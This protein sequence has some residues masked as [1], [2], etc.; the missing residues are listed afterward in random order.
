MSEETSVVANKTVGAPGAGTDAC[1]TLAEAF[2]SLGLHRPMRLNRYQAG[3]ELTYDVTGVS[4]AVRATVRLKIEK[5]VGGGFAGQ[6]YRATVLAVEGQPIAGLDVGGTYALK[7]L[8]PPSPGN[9]RFRDT[10]YAVGFQGPFSLQVNPAAMRAGAIWQK[11][12]RRASAIRFSD[13]GAVKDILCTFVDGRLGSCGELSEW[14]EGRQWRFE[15]DDHIDLRGKYLRGKPVEVAQLGSPEYLAKRR[16]MAEFVA[17]LHEMG[18]PEL[19][20]QYEWGT[21]KSQ[22]NV[23]KRDGMDD[24][25]AAGLTALD[26]RA[27]LALLPFLPM[28]PGDFRLIAKGIARGSLVQFDRGD[29]VRLE[30]FMN[31]H[32]DRF[33]DLWP[34]LGELQQVEKAY[35]DS[36]PD[37]THHHVRL[38]C[39]GQLWGSILDG[40]V[41]SWR[42]RNVTDDATT[43]ALRRSRALT[44][45]F[46]LLGLVGMVC[47]L[48]AACVL[49]L[50]ILHRHTQP[51]TLRVVL[52]ALVFAVVGPLAGKLFRRVAGREDYR[53]HYGAV[54]SSPG[55]FC[56]ALRGRSIEKVMA[57]YCAGRMSADRAVRTAGSPGR[58]LLHL[59]LSFLPA[60]LHRFLTDRA[61][62]GQVMRNVALRPVHLYFNAQARESWLRDM[63][64][65]GRRRGML[66]AE[67]AAEI[68][69]RLHE[70]FIQKYLKSLAV[71]V[72]LMPAGHVI[73]AIIGLCVALKYGKSLGE[74]LVIAG[75]IVAFFQVTPISPGSCLRGLYV[76][77]LVVKERNFKDYNIAVFLAFFKY[78]GYLAF[79]IQMTSRYPTLARFMAAHWATG[80][81]NYVPVFGE[82]GGLLEHAVFDTFYNRPLTLRRRAGLRARR[83]SALPARVWHAAVLAVVAAGVLVAFHKV[84]HAGAAPTLRQMWYLVPWPLLTAGYLTALWAGRTKGSKR[85]LLG[86]LVGLATAML[87]CGWSALAG[88]GASAGAVGS[89]AWREDLGLNLLGSGF[90]FTVLTLLGALAEELHVS[91]KDCR[92]T[93][94]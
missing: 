94:D 49:I 67:D 43:A 1:R 33:K 19:A 93:G 4:P 44:V 72:C 3:D 46:G 31:A 61:Y 81:A 37:V 90:I 26:F 75:G 21:C 51:I 80:A 32:S 62:A 41:T 74:G 20:R 22:P 86:L 25:P 17:M 85:I 70:P 73:S 82:Y 39:D 59:P 14:V 88:P 69:G 53:R 28:S 16:F 15:V 83:R 77:F 7:I 58:Y 60:G 5:F 8:L 52:V 71:H 11:L 54:F 56:R 24:D 63:V 18:A 89:V 9:T 40:A 34:A 48:A 6:V 45:G 23:M 36:L 78:V 57:W 91:D 2:A 13:D 64:G 87:Y 12:I 92:Q 27:G 66:S 76:L 35:R 10:L 42:I 47:V 29:L 65:Q 55:Y 50:A 68:E 79:P 38:F 30:A 84:A